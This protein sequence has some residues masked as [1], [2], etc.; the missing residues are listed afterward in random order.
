MGVIRKPRAGDQTGNG[1]MQIT[2]N[3]E[4]TAFAPNLQEGSLLNELFAATQS[5]CLKSL[6]EMGVSNRVLYDFEKGIAGYFSF[7]PI[8]V[9][10]KF[11]TPSETGVEAFIMPAN[12]YED[13]AIDDLV[14]I[15]TRF[16]SDC[17]ILYPAHI[18]HRS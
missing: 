8:E 10:K 9:S 16:Q 7:C 6:N 5:A 4:N 13:G 2:S 17:H 15:V 12:R 3:N 14:R 11:Y 18:P 1:D